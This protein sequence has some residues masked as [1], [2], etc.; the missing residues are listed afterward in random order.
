[1]QTQAITKLSRG[2][3]HDEP[4]SALAYWG[5]GFAGIALMLAVCFFA[6][7]RF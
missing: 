5:T 6:G 3:V 1:M 4:Q 2:R 7:L